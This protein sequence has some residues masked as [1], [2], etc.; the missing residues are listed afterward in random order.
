MNSERSENGNQLYGMIGR[1]LGRRGYGSHNT[2]I[3]SGLVL[4]MVDL[5]SR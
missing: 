1:G 3:G 4:G 5:R 2:T